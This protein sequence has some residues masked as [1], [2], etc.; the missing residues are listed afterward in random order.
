[1]KYDE[2]A[3][4]KVMTFAEVAHAAG[5]SLS[6]LRREIARGSGPEVISLSPRRKGV[7]STD[8]NRWLDARTSAALSC[9]KSETKG[10]TQ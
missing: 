7:R 2:L 3:G 1:M 4:N 5:I 6:T 10:D 9:L 8:Y